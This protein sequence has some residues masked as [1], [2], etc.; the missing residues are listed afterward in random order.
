MAKWTASTSDG[1]LDVIYDDAL[2]VDFSSLGF[3][4]YAVCANLPYNV[5]TELLIGWLKKIANGERISSL[6]LMF[7]KEVALRITARPGD[8]HYGRL[9]VLTSLIA[10]VNDMFSAAETSS[11]ESITALANAATKIP[12]F[13]KLAFMKTSVTIL[14]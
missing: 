14:F 7:Q 5:G 1:R 3:F 9:A 11:V 8:E 13:K 4:E 6:T 2:N 12:F 10:R